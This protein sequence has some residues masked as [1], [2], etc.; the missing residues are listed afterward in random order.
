VAYARIAFFNPQTIASY[1]IA[2]E[3]LFNLLFNNFIIVEKPPETDLD[4]LVFPS[5]KSSVLRLSNV[6]LNHSAVPVSRLCY[7]LTPESGQCYAR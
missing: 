2:Q 1:I 5:L 6:S 4:L 3:A 7:F